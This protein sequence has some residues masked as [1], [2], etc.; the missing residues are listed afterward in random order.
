MRDRLLQAWIIAQM[1]FNSTR[2]LD[3]ANFY[4][5]CRFAGILETVVH[6]FSRLCRFFVFE[7]ESEFMRQYMDLSH[8][9]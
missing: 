5:Q 9:S 3:P 4:P 1:T 6:L 8:Y 2:A 7:I